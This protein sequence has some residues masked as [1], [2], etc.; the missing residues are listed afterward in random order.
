MRAVTSGLTAEVCL[1]SVRRSATLCFKHDFEDVSGDGLAPSERPGRKFNG[2]IPTK[3][4]GDTPRSDGM[5][6]LHDPPR[7]RDERDIDGKSH[8]KR[9]DRV[10]RR[11]DHRLAVG[12]RLA[13]E[14]AAPPA[15]RVERR[16]QPMRQDAS[17]PGVLQH[18]GRP[19][20]PK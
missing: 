16:D 6:G 3:G 7:S 8:E 4:A 13:P 14:Q 11:D 5:A 20:I 15:L 17:V 9:V 1:V 12:E 19:G 18:P 2:G 10:A